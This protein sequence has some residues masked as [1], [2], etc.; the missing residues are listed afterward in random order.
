MRNRNRAKPERLALFPTESY[1]FSSVLIIICH[2][3]SNLANFL[4]QL[5]CLEW[6][7]MV[8]N[9]LEWSEVSEMSEMSKMSN[10]LDT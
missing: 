3:I 4:K 1:S 8:W 10:S 2:S 5:I 7:G 6:S 9:G